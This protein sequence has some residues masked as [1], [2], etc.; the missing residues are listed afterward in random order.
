M[1]FAMLQNIKKPLV[2]QRFE[3]TGKVDKI[4]Y[5]TCRLRRL[6]ERFEIFGPQKY[7]KALGFHSKFNA[8]LAF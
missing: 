2:K 6:L 5:K 1:R 4:P 7:Q 3:A 8:I